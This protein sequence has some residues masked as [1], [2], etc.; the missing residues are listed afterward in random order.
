MDTQNAQV[1]QLFT[2]SEV[3]D[4]LKMNPQVIARKLQAAR[5]RAIRSEKIGAS[6]TSS[7]S[8]FLRSIRT[9]VRS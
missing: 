4:I 5:S 1:P 7:Y 8:R 3:A 9:S 2:S 6:R